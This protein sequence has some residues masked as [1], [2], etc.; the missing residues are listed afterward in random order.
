VSA[1]LDS[2]AIEW[3]FGR[4][5]IVSWKSFNCRAVDFLG[6]TQLHRRRGTKKHPKA[7]V[8]GLG[9]TQCFLA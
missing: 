8:A 2:V 6:V 7:I 5:Q 4:V 3:A 9:E 1:D